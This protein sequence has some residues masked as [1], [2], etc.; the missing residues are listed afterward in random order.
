MGMK[1]QTGEGRVSSSAY[2][3]RVAG[4]AKAPGRGASL[5]SRPRGCFV[6]G[7]GAVLFHWQNF[8]SPGEKW[9]SGE[10]VFFLCFCCMGV[11]DP[12][13]VAQAPLGL[14]ISACVLPEARWVGVGPSGQERMLRGLACDGVTKGWPW[15]VSVLVKEM[16]GEN[17][18][19]W[20]MGAVTCAETSAA[21]GTG[22]EGSGASVPVAGIPLILSSRGLTEPGE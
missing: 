6:M 17:R 15:G 20:P 14:D 1:P 2:R 8:I 16:P 21:G 22:G 7:S 18:T 13:H 9:S 19:K 4:P 5:W 12:E 3:T 11:A 10:G